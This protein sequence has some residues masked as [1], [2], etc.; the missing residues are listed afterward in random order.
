[1]LLQSSLLHMEQIPFSLQTH[2]SQH[3]TPPPASP[4]LSSVYRPFSE[5]LHNLLHNVSKPVS[6][7]SFHVFLLYTNTAFSYSY[8]DIVKSIWDAIINNL[9]F[10]LYCVLHILLTFMYFIHSYNLTESGLIN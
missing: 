4:V 8:P 2:I 10:I 1:M 3:I 7:H 5:F 6:H 9:T